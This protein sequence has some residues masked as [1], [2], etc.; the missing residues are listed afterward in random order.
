MT[1]IKKVLFIG[2]KQLGLRILEELYTL[3][4]H[5]LIGVMTIDD[6]GDARSKYQEIKHFAQTRGLQF[7]TAV[8][9]SHSEQFVRQLRPDLCFVVNWYWIMG[10]ECL[11]SVPFGFIGIH[12]SLLPKYRGCSP[13]I[14]A[15]IKGE[16]EVGFSIF[17]FSSGMD[18]GAIWAQDRVIIESDDYISSVLGKIETKSLE[19]LQSI[20]LKILE[21]TIKPKEQKHELAT[22]C[23]QRF[24]RDGNIDWSKSA[25]DIY[26][27][28]RAQSD[29]YP[30][31]FT[32][33]EGQLLKIWRA[34]CFER[35]YFGTP[36]QVAGVINGEVIV[37]CGDDSAIVLDELEKDGRRGKAREFI[38]S[39][40]GR[41]SMR[42]VD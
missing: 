13:L 40:K 24:P 12:N 1:E 21:G 18:E 37:V 33:Y 5:I 29:P 11:S 9:R 25:I 22:Y 28:V 2:S 23:A 41:F 31:A 17:S 32:Y 27:F 4:P 14:W 38:K 39:F 35:P 30:G 19:I 3:S 16:R 10:K 34:R 7:C 15:I 42:Q 36:G 20:Y 6:I 26:N 8:N